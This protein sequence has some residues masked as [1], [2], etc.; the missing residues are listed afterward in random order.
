MKFWED[1]S[2]KNRRYAVLGAAAAVFSIVVAILPTGGERERAVKEEP[3]IRAVLTDRE[4][5]DARFERLM[6]QMENIRD[7]SRETKKEIERF[8]RDMERLQAGE[9]GETLNKE[10]R[11]MDE[12]LKVL[13]KNAELGPS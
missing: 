4:S 10:L 3:A 5:G 11:K 1:L 2:A 7:D 9:I 6:A 8:R 12:K 13:E